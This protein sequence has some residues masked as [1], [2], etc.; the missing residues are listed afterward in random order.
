MNLAVNARDAMPEGGRLL[1]ET[2]NVDIDE[3]SARPLRAFGTRSWVRLRVQDTG[4]GMTDEVKAHLFEPFFTTKKP[5]EGSGLGLATSYGIVLQNGGRILAA[6][7]VGLGST[8]EIFLPAVDAPASAPVEPSAPR[9]DTA[10]H[11]SL[12]LVED[13]PFVRRLAARA[14][15][16]GGYVVDE[17]A[18]GEEALAA[19]RARPNAYRLLVTDVIMP[20]MRGT[21]LARTLRAENPGLRVLLISG[22]ADKRVLQPEIE[23]LGT[24]ILVKPF[25]PEV[26]L[27][28][29]RETLDKA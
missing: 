6:S 5:G 10:G 22:Y 17:A 3:Q 24:T 4:V 27:R 12:L 7:E 28:H 13:D 8:F 19:A 2:A 1:L 25:G 11:E 26:L 20:G 23:S 18:S 14:L 16:A 21:E 29:V 9:A 15:R